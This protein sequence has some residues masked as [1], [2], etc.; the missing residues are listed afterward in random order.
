MQKFVESWTS[1]DAEREEGAGQAG[2]VTEERDAAIGGRA[3]FAEVGDEPSVKRG[4]VHV[5]N[6]CGN[7]EK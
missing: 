1:I 3:L 7:L 2:A 6:I 4:R 5:S